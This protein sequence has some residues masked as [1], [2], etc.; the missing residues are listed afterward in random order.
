M[1][2]PSHA[3][4]TVT[5]EGEIRASRAPALERWSWALYDFANT[6]FSMNIAT[7][8]FAVWLVSDLHASNTMVA[9]G[10]GI[11]SALI[12]I[13]IPIFGAISDSTQRRKPWVVWFTLLTC[14]ATAFLGIVGQTQVP[15]IGD[16][17][18][19]P[20]SSAP[21]VLSGT[22]AVLIIASFVAANYSYQGALPFYNAM[23][24]ELVP[25]NEQGRLSGAGTA[26]GYFGAIVGVLLV[27]PF[28]S[29]SM[30]L[31]GNISP[32]VMDAL[33]S[34]IP[35]TSHGGRVSTFVPT[36]ILFLLFSLPLFL[37]CR[38]H[39]AR[40]G[41]RGIPWRTAFA[42]VGH[43]IRDA[44]KYPG[45]LRFLIAS[46]LYQD[47]IGTIIANMALYAVMAMGF[48]KGLETTLFVVLTVPAVIGSYVI[49]RLVDRIGPKKSLV[50]TIISWVVLLILMVMVPNR[51]GFWIVGGLIG[52]IF[53]GVATAERPLLLTLV[54]DVEAGRFFSLMV[55]S[56]RAAAIVGPFVW[57]FTVDGMIPSFG[58]GTAYRA[59]VVTVA[60]GMAASLA[61]LWGVP[62]KWK[63]TTTGPSD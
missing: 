59:G 46:F 18:I 51:T 1:S 21:Y 26:L 25:P 37:F 5:G 12:A 43:T 6:I 36:A 60:I 40:K 17:I 35:F 8:Y 19:D 4:P 31:L 23:M 62:D 63:K 48:K 50:F 54:P 47:A 41:K 39:N 10:N 27:T 44:K 32:A 13:S 16:S 58:T 52:L 20:I 55:L 3:Q 2:H 9:L 38:D 34:V 42:E 11:S 56:S 29:S 61:L 45:S 24:A 28:F 30:P 7:L 57:A 14:A 15:L 22:V 49:G 33:R 53:G